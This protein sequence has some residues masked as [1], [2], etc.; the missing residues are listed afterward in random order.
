MVV[1]GLAAHVE[2]LATAYA[3]A[4]HEVVVLTR[5]HPYAPDDA[6]VDGVRV[7][8]AHVDLPWVPDDAFVSLVSSGNHHLVKLLARLGSWQ[9]DVVH[10]HDWLVAWSGDV[11]RTIL[12]VP[13]VA[14]IHAT[15]RGRHQGYLSSPMSETINAIEW[16]LTYQ[17]TEVIACSNFMVDEVV[18]GFQLPRRKVHM[19]PNGVDPSAWQMDEVPPRLSSGPLVVSWG[20]LQY[21]KGFHTLVSAAA[22]VRGRHPDVRVVIVG[23]G[24]YAED[25][26]RQARAEG[27]EDII[28]FAGFVP[29]AELLALLHQ[30]TCAVIP[31][32]YEPFG[33]V[34]LE[35]LAAGAPLVA[36]A[37]GGLR[38]VLDG[39]GAGLLF[40]AG[41]VGALADAITRVI[42]DAALR[43]AMTAAGGAL[44]GGRYSWDVIAQQ[45][46]EVYRVAGA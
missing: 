26:H 20:R 15:E 11:L 33:I 23:R 8:R 16:W 5:A 25:L 14:T 34:A 43:S 10:A 28:R 4:G 32:L 6:E 46:I 39:T 2:G 9:P 22:R 7:L 30:A 31:S 44:V 1:G 24:T 36:A 27:V 3:R 40:P 45:T 35:A 29:D 19:V 41:D 37:S 17:A 42:D 21:E 13:F 38:E 18:H 12:D